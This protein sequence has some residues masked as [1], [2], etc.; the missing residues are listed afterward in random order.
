MTDNPRSCNIFAALRLVFTIQ[1]RVTTYPTFDHTWYAPRLDLLGMIEVNFACFC[2][3]IPV[4]WPVVVE[5]FSNISNIFVTHEI[6]VEVSHRNH[7]YVNAES[8]DGIEL[9]VKRGEPSRSS[10]VQRG[11]H[12]GMHSREG[13]EASLGL[14]YSKGERNDH[15]QD[16]YILDQVDPL[17]IKTIV[18]M[19]SEI[20]T[21]TR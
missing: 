12:D 17:R 11:S 16:D 19:G 6:K 1:Q 13:S 2:A 21:G 7:G 8:D 9:H 10:R 5:R 3:S 20:T 15:Y 18:A 14:K 4:F